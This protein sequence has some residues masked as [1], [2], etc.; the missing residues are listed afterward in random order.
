MYG[1]NVYGESTGRGEEIADCIV[2]VVPRTGNETI[3]G[4][5]KPDGHGAT[6]TARGTRNGG[7]DVRVNTLRVETGFRISNKRF[8]EDANGLAPDGFALVPIVMQMEGT[9]ASEVWFRVLVEDSIRMRMN[10]N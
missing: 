4:E 10:Q 2:F 1:F 9:N 7:E 3:T 5:V 8:N 6:F